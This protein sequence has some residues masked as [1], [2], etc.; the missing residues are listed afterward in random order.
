MR[1]GAHHPITWLVVGPAQ[2]DVCL[3]S[4]VEQLQREKRRSSAGG[5]EGAVEQNEEC[6][7]PPTGYSW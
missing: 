1:G 3:L 5:E 2:L 4:P 7:L 6:T